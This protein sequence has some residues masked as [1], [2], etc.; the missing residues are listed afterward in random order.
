M[1]WAFEFSIRTRSTSDA[2][3]KHWKRMNRIH[4]DI[5]K[6][7][8]WRL[9]TSESF[10]NISTKEQTGCPSRART[11]DQVINSHLLYH[12]AIGQL[13]WVI[14]TKWPK[15]SIWNTSNL[16]QFFH[17]TSIITKFYAK[18]HLYEEQHYPGVEKRSAIIHWNLWRENLQILKFFNSVFCL[19]Y[20]GFYLVQ[21]FK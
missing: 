21:P 5:D 19:L 13:T 7:R 16:M 6:K 2:M 12:W 14:N 1:S 20:C 18:K 17:S 8:N 3:Y 9:L 15:M 11:C 4:S 10:E